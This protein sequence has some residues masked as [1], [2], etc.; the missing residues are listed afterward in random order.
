MTNIDRGVIINST[1]TKQL[2]ERGIF[3]KKKFLK[4]KFSISSKKRISKFISDEKGSKKKEKLEEKEF[5]L[6]IWKKESLRTPMDNFN[7]T[8]QYVSGIAN[9]E[10]C[11]RSLYHR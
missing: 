6:R 1:K 5:P 11:D 7:C 3:L 10:T 4:T 9:V 8:T 2:K